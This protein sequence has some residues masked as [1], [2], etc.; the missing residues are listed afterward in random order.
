MRRFYFILFFTILGIQA[1]AQ[2]I[3]ETNTIPSTYDR[4]SI[5]VLLLDFG[6]ER[7]FEGVKEAYTKLAF[8]DKYYRNDIGVNVIRPNFSRAEF[9][10]KPNELVASLLKEQKV[11]EQVIAHWFSMKED[12]AMSLE[13]V[14]ERGMFNATD[15]AYLQAQSTKRGNTALMDY[16]TRLINL[17]YILV[18]DYKD[19]KT[20]AEAKVKDM[21]GWKADVNGYL[22]KI[23]YNEEIQN[24]FYD[25]WVDESDTP[26]SKADKKSRIQQITVPLSYVTK[27]SQ[28]TTSSQA[29]GT[30]QLGKFIKQ[31]SEEVLLTELVQKSYDEVLYSL[32]KG[33]EEFRV[34]T[35]V[36]QTRPIRAKIGKKEGIKTDYRFFAYEYV[37][38][39]KKNTVEPKFRGV[40]R[41][42]SNIID[43]RR[44][45]SGDMATTKFYQTAGRKIR[46]GYLLQQR[47]DFGASLILGYENGEVGGIY[48]RVDLRL[49]R[50]IGMKSTYLYGEIGFQSKDYG[51]ISW[52]D[53]NSISGSASGKATFLRYGA[54][55]AKG[56][57]FARNFE[58]APYVGA[59][60]ETAKYK[61]ED[62]DLSSLYIRAGANLALNLKHNF[63]IVGGAGVYSF[64]SK[65]SYGDFEL[66]ESWSDLFENRKGVSAM[67]G[68]RFQF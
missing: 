44:V 51:T 9:S 30:T 65:A 63:Q 36:H 18:L 17:S 67:I 20:M 13:L 12:G 23:D 29:E 54:G 48:G 66:E 55:I 52:I 38:N 16:G 50:F 2:N 11:A 42:T 25:S 60:L 68:I 26:E 64:I 10:V 34:K 15:A 41:A 58:L 35:T 24:A 40:I 5:T 37:Y 8:G 47:N 39:E 14:H 45:A 21:R 28:P 56:F 43:N 1:F 53:E 7:H 33:Y 19:I 27:V 22:F 59:G 31:K 3:S 6:S 4:S 57:H 32:E 61:D 49:G 62:E 46:A